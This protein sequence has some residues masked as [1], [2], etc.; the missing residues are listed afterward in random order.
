MSQLIFLNKRY[1]WPP[2]PSISSPLIG[3]D[4]RHELASIPDIISSFLP[5]I[6]I[7]EPKQ[8]LPLHDDNNDLLRPFLLP[9]QLNIIIDNF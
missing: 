2:S 3:N 9:N 5:L 1:S 7:P 8:S 4:N 6:S